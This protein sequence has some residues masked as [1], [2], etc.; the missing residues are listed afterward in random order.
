MTWKLDSN[1]KDFFSQCETWIVAASNL[2]EKSHSFILSLSQINNSFGQVFE[3][4]ERNMLPATLLLGNFLTVHFHLIRA[5]TGMVLTLAEHSSDFFS[6]GTEHCV[7]GV[8][9]TSSETAG[10]NDFVNLGIRNWWQTGFSPVKAGHLQPQ[11]CQK[12]TLVHF[13]L[14]YNNK[15]C[16]IWREF[17]E[18]NRW[19]LPLVG[20]FI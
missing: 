6:H 1:V 14:H 3:F 8:L 2:P 5:A 12:N 9:F 15:F 11:I 10:R 20:G 4:S 18:R 7:L 16:Q 17:S 19:V 13:S